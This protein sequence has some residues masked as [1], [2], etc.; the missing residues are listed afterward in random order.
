[1]IGAPNSEA[2]KRKAEEAARGFHPVHV[3]PDF[4]G[5]AYV[6]WRDDAID[7]DLNYPADTKNGGAIQGRRV[8]ALLQRIGM[9]E[10]I[11]AAYGDDPDIEPEFLVH[12]LRQALR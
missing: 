4:D 5:S 1:M 7:W 2:R 12:Q 8:L 10:G 6:A 11:L 9:V 3:L